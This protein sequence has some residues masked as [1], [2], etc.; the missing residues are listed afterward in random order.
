MGAT[1]HRARGPA[2]NPGGGTSARGAGPP[3]TGPRRA[4]R[5]RDAGRPLLLRPGDPGA[6]HLG[7]A[8]LLQQVLQVEVGERRAHAAP[9]LALARLERHPAGAGARGRGDA[10][11]RGRAEPGV[12]APRACG[13]EAAEAAETEGTRRGWARH[14]PAGGA[15]GGRGRSPAPPRPRARL[16]PRPRARLPGPDWAGPPPPRPLELG[17]FVSPS[18]RGRRGSVRGLC[19][20][21][22]QLQAL[23][24]NRRRHRT[25]R[26]RVFRLLCGGYTVIYV[27]PVV[28][29]WKEDLLAS[30]GKL[31]LLRLRLLLFTPRKN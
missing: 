1:T 25:L 14:H 5:P 8:A 23:P 11:T 28:Q 12:R 30:N 3:R 13:A 27:S 6:A 4:A 18:S 10:E 24:G 9:A 29:R 2:R 22:L 20:R 15:P 26:K 17:L 31:F 21:P 16:P 7:P 19:W